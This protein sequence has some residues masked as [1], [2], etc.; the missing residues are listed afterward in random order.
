MIAL[1]NNTDR[2]S[3]AEK[4]SRN[5]KSMNIR[6]INRS[7]KCISYYLVKQL[8]YLFKCESFDYIIMLCLLIRSDSLCSRNKVVPCSRL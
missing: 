7:C 8:K 6:D 4:D 5:L 1:K 2:L 3:L